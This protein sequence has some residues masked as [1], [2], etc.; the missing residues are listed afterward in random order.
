MEP[1]VDLAADAADSASDF[2]RQLVGDLDTA[3]AR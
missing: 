1:R 3:N 2:A